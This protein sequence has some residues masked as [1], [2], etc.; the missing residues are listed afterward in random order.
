MNKDMQFFIKNTLRFIPDELYLKLAFYL[1]FRRKLNLKDPR[2]LSEKIQ[3]LKLNYRENRFSD[4]VDKYLVKDIVKRKIGEKYIIKT[5]GVWNSF[6]E[7]NFN[8]LPN[9]F[10]LKCN[11]DSGGIAIC[12]DKSDFDIESARRIIETHLKRNYFWHGREW[13]YKNVK[14][15]ILAEELLETKTGE[16]LRD[17]KF[18]CF[19]GKM[20]IFKVDCDRFSS[21]KA[22][23]FDANK[24]VLPFSEKIFKPGVGDMVPSLPDNIDTMIAN[25][26]KLAEDLKFARVDFYNIDGKIYFGEITLYPASGMDVFDPEEWDYKLGDFLDLEK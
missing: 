24:N 18:F 1:K 19:G 5:Y 26:E 15:V 22:F 21:H 13:A 10:V 9:K 20:K 12:K 4:L 23:Y 3:W 25:A 8:S 14:P 7:I 6:E 2:S 11:H 17:Y 16:D